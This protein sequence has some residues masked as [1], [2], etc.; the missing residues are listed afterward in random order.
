MAAKIYDVLVVGGGHAGAEAALVA[1]RMG[2]ATALVSFDSKRVGQM[3]CNPAIG[4]LGKGQLVKE[5]DA[6]F[7]EMG[8]AI[9]DTGIQFRI[10]NSS[11]GPAV[12][13]SRAQADRAAY[14]A[15]VTKA[16]Q[17]CPNLDL[18]QAAVERLEVR[19]GR[20]VGITTGSGELLSSRTTI[21]TTGTF[22][23]GL[24][25]T[26][27]A[28]T[29]GGRVGESAAYGLSESIRS[30]GLRMGRM[31]TGTPPRLAYSTIDF[32]RLVE[33]PGDDPI[34]PFSFRTKRIHRPQISCWM[35]NTTAETHAI[36]GEN[37]ERS[38]MF[39][40]QIQ[41]RGP[42]YCPSIE[43]KVFRFKDKL[44]HNIFLEPEGYDTEI[45]YPNGIS[46]SLPKD[47]QEAFLRTIPGLEHAVILQPGYAV[48][49]DHVDPTELDR[50]LAP[51][52]IQGLYCA[53]QINGTSGYEEAAAQGIIAGINAALEVLG[54]EPLVLS[55]DQ[56]YIGVMV[57]D[58]T[59][60]GVMEP[61]RMFTSRAEYRLK[62]RE[63]NADARLTPIARELGLV[64]EPDWREYNERQER[65]A[66]E[67]LRL[68]RT[69]VKPTAE[70]NE[71]LRSLESAEL[72]DAL[73]LAT[74]LRRPEI[75]YEHLAAQWPPEVSLA[76]SELTTLETE[77]KFA[78]YFKR[79]EQDIERVRRMEEIEIP[80]D[81]SF[82]R[83]SG[84]SVEVCERLSQLRPRTLGQASRI[85]GVTPAAVSLLSIYLR[86][87][88]AAPAR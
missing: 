63:D 58:L 7:G 22:L 44:S 86:R 18:I 47:V 85:S 43:D 12:R 49:Y 59:T 62:L 79:Q 4:G 61:Y 74:L 17:E 41:S 55:R 77:I 28:Q 6:L 40:G 80:N 83:I 30:L 60:L 68:E 71:W 3:S 35:T 66:A 5:V 78:G 42:R 2:C 11:K 87:A 73:P 54:K 82:R 20:V 50:T 31:K 21:L 16:V 72:F 13:S 38:P 36:I 48:E 26:G 64:S 29:K 75:R 23:G 1:A 37:V 84:L 57:D 32:S 88:D 45:V 69:T 70:A 39:N 34:K 9:D 14:R 15:R 52:S 33:Q 46:T 53:G 24:M 81:F 19:G 51:K 27:E 10:L 67:R 76:D 56:A 25:H 8:R 65:I